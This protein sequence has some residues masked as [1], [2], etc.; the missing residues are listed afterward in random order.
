[1]E[2]SCLFVLLLAIA[3]CQV[4]GFVRNFHFIRVEHETLGDTGNADSIECS[5]GKEMFVR[6][7]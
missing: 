6:N 7:I 1:M 2:V 4:F 5:I 3:Q